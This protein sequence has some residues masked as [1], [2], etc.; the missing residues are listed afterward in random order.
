MNKINSYFYNQTTREKTRLNIDKNKESI[1]NS[2][3]IHDYN[4]IHYQCPYSE[5]YNKNKFIL[6][7][8]KNKIPTKNVENYDKINI[9]QQHNNRYFY[10]SMNFGNIPSKNNT[11]DNNLQKD[12]INNNTIHSYNDCP[13]K[14]KKY[15]RCNSIAYIK[16]RPNDLIKI[17]NP[18]NSMINTKFIRNSFKMKGRCL[19][20]SNIK[21]PQD[22]LKYNDIYDNDNNTSKKLFLPLSN[23]FIPKGGIQERNINKFSLKAQKNILNKK[24]FCKS[25]LKVIKNNL[26]SNKI[27]FF[28]NI[29]PT[30]PVS[31]YEVSFEEYKF[32]E[33][34]KALGVTNKKELNSLLKDIYISIKGNEK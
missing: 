2:Q 20:C 14:S 19:S 25:I 34:L 13:L 24:I 33:E 27:I 26:L 11:V 18:N 12:S 6:N 1:S 32:L 23:S 5:S 28:K 4:R 17:Q 8:T 10:S 15:N 3:Y 7:L 9:S 22:F 31:M 30:K 21:I 16:K 29:K